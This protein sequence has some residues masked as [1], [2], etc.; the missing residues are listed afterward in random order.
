MFGSTVLETA[1]GMAFV[2]L[3]VS[4]LVTASSEMVANALKLRAR[5]LRKGLA[6]MLAPGNSTAEEMSG[7][8]TAILQHPLVAGRAVPP[9]G[10]AAAGK[11]PGK[12]SGPSYIPT[13]VFSTALFDT[14]GLV[15]PS[16]GEWVQKL[17]TRLAALPATAEDLTPIVTA[18][19]GLLEELTE[20]LDGA[21]LRASLEKAAAGLSQTAA[22]IPA[23]QQTLTD[24]NAK[25][26]G[27]LSSGMLSWVKPMLTEITK[28]PTAQALQDLIAQIPATGTGAAVFHNRLRAWRDRLAL[29]PRPYALAL[30]GAR[31]LTA[32]LSDMGAALERLPDSDLKQ[33]L[34]LLNHEAGNDAAAFKAKVGEWFDTSMTR[35]SGWY[36]RQ[37]AWVNFGLGLVLAVLLNVDA[38]LILQRLS[39]DP[40]LRT[41][42]V[43]EAS[44]YAAQ[45][46][47]T[48]TAVATTPATSLAAA[49][50]STATA[51]P[52]A[53]TAAPTTPA[54]TLAE[55]EE[56]FQVT[57]TQLQELGLPIGWVTSGTPEAKSA[58]PLAEQRVRP[59]GADFL[60]GTGWKALG[61]LL[62]AHGLG[63]LLTAIA[64][65][66]G[67]P[68]WFDLLDKFMNIR[69]AGE[70]PP[71]G[72][73]PK[74]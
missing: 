23:L 8:E 20:A 6:A 29:S 18:V 54:P 24:I 42:L 56:H 36:K 55:A 10:T 26:N 9:A 73:S 67:A 63:W 32:N 72:K 44:A 69:H 57:R 21:D 46:A 58:R 3:L 15:S 68:F 41:T 4:V 31:S 45:T 49:P 35:V 34:L 52:P 70:R 12:G 47:A 13:K 1:I 66:I 17:Q 19:S 33:S 74:P 53:I 64:A 43:N 39:T 71:T 59:A 37:T 28:N 65:S 2:F 5:C 62:A 30:E 16:P 50:A 40:S 14:L 25:I 61:P 60:A 38:L 22:T 48:N 11:P 27:Q 51:T 7:L